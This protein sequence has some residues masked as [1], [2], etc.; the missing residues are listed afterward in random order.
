LSQATPAG[1]LLVVCLAA[2]LLAPRA[3][4]AEALRQPFCGTSSGARF[5]Q[6]VAAEATLPP[7]TLLQVLQEPPAVPADYQG[8]IRYELAVAGDFESI[9]FEVQTF[10]EL[11][12]YS[13]ERSDSFVNSE[14]NVISLFAF[15]GTLDQWLVLPW[16][17]DLDLTSPLVFS[18]L[19][20]IGPD[21][22]P[23]PI[24]MPLTLLPRKVPR[25][26]VTRRGA[27]L[28]YASN[29]VNIAM[30]DL[31]SHQLD[32]P[33][34]LGFVENE[35]ADFVRGELG[36][37]EYDELGIGLWQNEMTN[38]GAFHS[39]AQAGT[40]YPAYSVYTAAAFFQQG[41]W[42]HEIDHNW[43][44]RYDLPRLVGWNAP[45][46]GFHSRGT[47]APE[48]GLLCCSAYPIEKVKGRWR[49]QWIRDPHPFHPLELFAMGLIDADDVP[50]MTVFK[51][52]G[53]RDFAPNEVMRGATRRLSVEQVIEEYG[54]PAA[55]AKDYW[56][57][58][59]VVVSEK[60]LPKQTVSTLNFFLRRM[61]DPEGKVPGSFDA[62][63]GYRLDLR[64]SV[65][66]SELRVPKPPRNVSFPSIDKRE[67]PG[68]VLTR[69]L[70]GCIRP[71]ETLVLQGR[72][73]TGAIPALSLLPSNPDYPVLEDPGLASSTFRV[74]YVPEREDVY[75][76]LV[77]GVWPPAEPLPVKV[78]P[79]YVTG[80]CP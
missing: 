23:R 54:M 44:F 65:Q 6:T 71:G 53:L 40:I 32:N 66:A 27:R 12:T 9:G 47:V 61:E 18:E 16:S 55:A 50:E 11:T 2:A 30:P 19:L 28:Q 17:W 77:E 39:A 62:A 7:G 75:Q 33:G 49:T 57:A 1:A 26:K 38:P 22:S 37:F 51:R 69:A 56:H 60:L 45:F 29:L 35:I 24:F 5:L 78:G 15:E 8:T 79:I 68:L 10:T 21:V 13:A 3:L 74:E 36:D 48:P 52:Q 14:G 58:L 76:I 73:T 46:D 43:N 4:N 25:S 80:E 70:P 72:T 42:K 67:I 31:Y 34:S 64:T 63:T 59:P 20:Y 41:L